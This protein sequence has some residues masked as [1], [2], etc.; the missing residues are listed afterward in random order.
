MLDALEV[1]DET[2]E[3]R[4]VEVGAVEE[5]LTGD[6]DE[7]AIDDGLLALAVAEPLLVVVEGIVE[8]GLTKPGKSKF[9][10]SP[11]N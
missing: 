9:C 3:D 5:D 6:T 11:L 7:D 2:V 8:D 1:D 4:A 10:Q